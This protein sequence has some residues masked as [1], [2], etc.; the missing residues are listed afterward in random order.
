MFNKKNIFSILLLL[1]SHLSYAAVK[2][3]ESNSDFLILEAEAVKSV[4][5]AVP[6]NSRL[7]LQV[8][9]AEPASENSVKIGIVGKIAEQAV[10]QILF[11]GSYERL[12]VKVRFFNNLR[13]SS[14]SSPAFDS[15]LDNLLLNYT[16]SNNSHHRF[17][18]STCLPPAFPA[19][20]LS[21]N[22]TGIYKMSYQDFQ[23]LG[24]D[25]A[26]LNSRPI[27]MTNKGKAISIFISG[28]DDGVFSPNDA[29]FF[30]AEA[31]TE[32]AYTP[33]G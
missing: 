6:D 7:E 15:L 21:I 30:Y 3:L 28:E 20:K 32:E 5:I 12:R 14:L 8:L 29:L 33:Q 25:V 16:S 13:S 19:L 18:K 9:E 27:H 1:F 24:L 17:T 10:A 11:N 2:L 26:V 4:L 22:K 23:A 31:A